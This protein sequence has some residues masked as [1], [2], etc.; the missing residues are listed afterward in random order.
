MM[1]GGVAEQG[2]IGGRVAACA[3]SV[4]ASSHV[5]VRTEQRQELSTKPTSEEV[6]R[7]DVDRRVEENE[8]VGDL[9]E[10]VER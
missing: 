8:K 3:S 2:A 9:V 7:N 4:G 1:A 10:R 5:A 6:V